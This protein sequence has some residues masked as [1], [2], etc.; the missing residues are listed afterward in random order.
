MIRMPEAGDYRKLF[1]VGCPRSGTTWLQLLLA[2]HAE[3][4]TAPETQIFA[5]YLAQLERQWRLEHEGSDK[6]Q[7]RAGLSRLLS[8]DEFASL[9]R[10]SARLV[11]DKIRSG[12]PGCAVVAEKSPKHALHAAFIQ[13]LFPDALFLNVIRDPRDTAVSLIAASQ[14]WGRDWAPPNA[15]QAARMWVDH[16]HGARKAAEIPSRYY[17]VQYEQLKADAVREL[18]S[19]L[20]WIGVGA[21]PAECAAAVAAC[22]FKEL[23]KR[24][25]SDDLPLPGSQSPQG[26][27]RKGESNGWRDELSNADVRVVEHIC[28]PLMAEFGYERSVKA[29][30]SPPF[31]IL[32]HDGVQRVR[33][34]VDWQLA[35]LLMR[36]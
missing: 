35:R 7:G 3:I 24:K 26:F 19:I 13:Q 6:L 14:S 1:I 2:Q 8:D 17:E 25:V 12:R 21:D 33:E 23:K 15:V 20:E 29:R 32:A 34:S 30:R 4:A 31:K 10:Q 27:F 28:G 9:C 36:V 16:I 18:Q 22:D 5:Y 11:L